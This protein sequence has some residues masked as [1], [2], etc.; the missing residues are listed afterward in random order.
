MHVFVS[1]SPDDEDLKKELLKHLAPAIRA[2]VLSPWDAS[3]VVVGDESPA[4]IEAELG[5]AEVALVLLSASYLDQGCP[6]E[7]DLGRIK[8]RQAADG[9]RIVPVVL[10]PC[11]WQSDPRIKDLQVLPRD[12]R[13]LRSRRDREEALVDV[14]REIVALALGA[15][16]S[17]ARAP[18]TRPVSRREAAPA[19]ALNWRDPGSVLSAAIAA[20]PAINYALGVACL[21]A[22]VAIVT[23]G[24]RFDAGTATVGTLVVMAL[25]VV[26]IALAVVAR[27]QRRLVLSAMVLTWAV[28]VLTLCSSAL[29]LGS[30]FFHWPRPLRCLVHDEPCA[31]A[32]RRGDEVPAAN[33]MSAAAQVPAPAAAALSATSPAAAPS[34]PAAVAVEVNSG[35]VIEDSPGAEMRNGA[36]LPLPNGPARLNSGNRMKGSK[37]AKMDNSLQVTP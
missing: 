30:L 18:G 13:P 2:G 27:Q 35:N 28:L 24:A 7:R 12:G 16:P 20:V 19:P 22:V 9:L 37:G 5:R 14:C 6:A 8:E 26:L 15:S 36:V 4:V 10:S 21:G 23:L 34:T 17:A 32:T 25:M 33:G 3:K 1:Y 29:L 31:Q 11:D